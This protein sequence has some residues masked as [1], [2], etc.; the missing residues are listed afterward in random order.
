MAGKP[1]IMNKDILASKI[2]ENEKC[3]LLVDYGNV[4]DIKNA[5]LKLINDPRLCEKLGNNGRKA[6]ENKYSW[7][8]M[9]K[10]LLNE[11]NQIQTIKGNYN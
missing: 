4:N 6:Y 2:V 9:E 3:G 11:Y 1:I 8:I 7:K 5:L 10:R